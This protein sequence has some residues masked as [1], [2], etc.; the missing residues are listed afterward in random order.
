MFHFL[1]NDIREQKN[2]GMRT[3]T[4]VDNTVSDLRESHVVESQITLLV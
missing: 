3:Q 1:E 2:Y 4:S